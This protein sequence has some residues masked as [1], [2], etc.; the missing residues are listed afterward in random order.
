MT[1][2]VSSVFLGLKKNSLLR[3]EGLHRNSDK[4]KREA[5]SVVAVVKTRGTFVVAPVPNS[6]S[7]KVV[8][9]LLLSPSVKCTSKFVLMPKYFPWL[10]YE[11]FYPFISLST[12]GLMGVC[13]R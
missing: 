5:S 7:R 8:R 1:A 11:E 10:D 2:P 3:L 9:V 12:G 6:S 4:R 13:S